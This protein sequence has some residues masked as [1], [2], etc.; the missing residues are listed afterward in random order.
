[1]K[2]NSDHRYDM[3][4]D[5]GRSFLRPEA[6]RLFNQGKH[7][8]FRLIDESGRRLLNVLDYCLAIGNEIRDALHCPTRNPARFIARMASSTSHIAVEGISK[9]VEK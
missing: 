5:E 9:N 3:S 2:S 6:E 4:E 7:G 1:M 8:H